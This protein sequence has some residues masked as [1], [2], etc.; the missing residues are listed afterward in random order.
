MIP[1]HLS[2]YVLRALRVGTPP[3]TIR[4]SLLKNGWSDAEIA[5]ANAKAWATIQELAKNL[6]APPKKSS[7]LHINGPQLLLYLGGL[8]VI[9]AAIIFDSINWQQWTTAARII[10]IALPLVVC[11]GVGTWLWRGNRSQR[12]G[13]V[14]LLIGGL[15]LP[16][17]LL[18]VAQETDLFA[19]HAADAAFGIATLSLLVYAGFSFLFPTAVWSLLYLS[20][21]LITYL[22]FWGLTPVSGVFEAP[23]I[24]WL[25]LLPGT[26]YVLS[27]PWFERRGRKTEAQVATTLGAIT[28]VTATLWIF[29]LSTD[30]LLSMWLLPL[31][32]L[33]F[34]AIGGLLEL[35][36]WRRW[37][38]TPYTVGLGIVFLAL[39]RFGFDPKLGGLLPD[40]SPD[41][42]TTLGLASIVVGCVYLLIAVALGRIGHPDVKELNNFRPFF[43]LV[44]PAWIIGALF[45]LGSNGS[46]P[47]YELLTLLATVLF[48]AASVPTGSRQFLAVGTLGLL[49]FIYAIGYEYF[50][51][52][53]GWPLTVLGAGL[54][55]M[56]V[57]VLIHWLQ[58]Q[59]LPRRRALRQE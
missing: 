3:E 24:A 55:S 58:T 42:L 38:R 40:T 26:L 49:L 35:Q 50:N 53:I 25:T 39:A 44:G 31:L 4:A 45:F 6:P 12:E 23:T 43:L 51:N 13:L 7:L 1:S 8:L 46:Q 30:D 48:I 41:T 14:F 36:G 20:A 34:V 32:G 19:S 56:I 22:T 5:E 54:L 29:S 37:S 15:L 17:L 27:S 28:L 9:V 18:L 52:Q 11:L 33:I 21:G 57:G 59:V 47:L 2:T 10:A 16:F